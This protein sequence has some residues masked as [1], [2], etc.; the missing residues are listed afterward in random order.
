MFDQ[1]ECA[2]CFEE[3]V[4][5]QKNKINVQLLRNSIENCEKYVNKIL[6]TTLVLRCEHS[7]HLGCF[8]NYIKS[9]YKTWKQG[10]GCNVFYM[11]CPLCRNIVDTS[12][13]RLIIKSFN[14]IKNITTFINKQMSKLKIKVLFAKLYLDCKKV[15]K[16][17]V[18]LSRIY[19]YIDLYEEYEFLNKKIQIMT[20]ETDCLYNKMS[21]RKY[22]IFIF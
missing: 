9:K 13:L 18:S 19:N 17:D 5:S 22:E 8:I 16:F 10:K 21:Q 20:K 14:S 1:H 2:F 3:L 15:L 4:F 12:E 11:S 6:Y 7:F